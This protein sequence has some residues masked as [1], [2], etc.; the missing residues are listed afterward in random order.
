[1]ASI[2]R[3]ISER[4]SAQAA[5]GNSGTLQPKGDLIDFGNPDSLRGALRHTQR[6]WI[7][8][9]VSGVLPGAGTRISGSYMMTDYRAA[10]PAHRYMTQRQSPDLGLNVQIRQPIPAFGIFAGRLEA[11]AEMRNLLQQG[12]LPLQG[13]N[14]RRIILLPSPRT[15]RGGLAFIF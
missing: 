12:Y 1:M 6:S 4:W 13:T 15:V 9:R 11:V 14:G 10:L 8:M 2:D 5:F 3:R 7:N